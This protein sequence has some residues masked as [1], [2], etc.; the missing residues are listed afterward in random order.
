MR[1]EIERVK[2]LW[3]RKGERIVGKNCGKERVKYVLDVFGE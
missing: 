1:F 2:E 3:E